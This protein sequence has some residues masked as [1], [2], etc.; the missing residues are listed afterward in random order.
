MWREVSLE[1]RCLCRG[2]K[3]SGCCSG[4]A[5]CK[6][7]LEVKIMYSP[8]SLSFPMQFQVKLELFRVM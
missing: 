8:N 5:S 7:R 2:V 1:N 4:M 6:D 3:F